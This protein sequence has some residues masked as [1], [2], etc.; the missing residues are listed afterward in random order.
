MK[1][2]SEKVPAFEELGTRLR[3][4]AGLNNE[5]NESVLGGQKPEFSHLFLKFKCENPSVVAGA[6]EEAVE[7][8]KEFLGELNESLQPIIE[9]L[10]I[11]VLT[12][13]DGVAMVLN[14]DT[15]PILG[16]YVMMAMSSVQPLEQLHPEVDLKLGKTKKMTEENAIG[17]GGMVSL[18]I[19]SKSVVDALINNNLTLPSKEMESKLQKAIK[20]KLGIEVSMFL[21]FINAKSLDLC[22]TMYEIDETKFDFKFNLKNTVQQK[23]KQMSENPILAVVRSME[24]VKE[25]VETLTSNGVSEMNLGVTAGSLNV[26]LDVAADLGEVIKMVLEEDD[27]D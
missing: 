16:P 27:E 12:L 19:Q 23:L 14:L 7:G 11:N 3:V 8:L 13:D 18:N 4:R 2:V 6:Y 21:S 22:L 20:Q 24:F 5:I 26:R 17:G 15:H 25:F 10:E 9:Q 1:V